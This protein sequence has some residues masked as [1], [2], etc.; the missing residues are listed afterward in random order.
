MQTFIIIIFIFL[1]FVGLIFNVFVFFYV[2]DINEK[3]NKKMHNNLLFRKVYQYIIVNRNFQNLNTKI[4]AL[5][6]IF[7]C[8][9]FIIALIYRL[10]NPI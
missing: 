2:E 5:S 7:A 6:G 1:S 10:F 8:L 9:L 3:H 4:A